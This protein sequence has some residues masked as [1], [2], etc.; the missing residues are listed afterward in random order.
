MTDEIQIN[1]PKRKRLRIF[2]LILLLIAILIVILVFIY[3]RQQQKITAVIPDTFLL[4]VSVTAPLQTWEEVESSS[5]WVNLRN[6][7][8][9][10]NFQKDLEAL[11][12]RLGPERNRKLLQIL[13][14]KQVA[15]IV[16]AI[17]TKTTAY[18]FAADLGLKIKLIQAATALKSTIFPES[19]D[20]AYD[21]RTFEGTEIH[22]IHLRAQ[23]QT[24]GYIFLR[25]IFLFSNDPQTLEKCIL[26]WQGK[27]TALS[28]NPDF[29]QVQ[30]NLNRGA[31]I[32]LYLNGAAAQ[33]WLRELLTP[34][35]QRNLKIL[36]DCIR[37]TG[38]GLKLEQNR[39]LVQGFSALDTTVAAPHLRHLLRQEAHKSALVEMIPNGTGF[40]S[41]LT[42][43][44][45][46]AI[47]QFS[48]FQLQQNPQ[49]WQDFQASERLVQKFIGINIDRDFLSWI[50]QD[51]GML[52]LPDAAFD[53]TPETVLFLKV[54]DQTQAR[55]SLE[56]IKQTVAERIPIN[57]KEKNYKG[58]LLGYLD[59]PFFLK[60]FFGGIFKKITKP[61]WCLIDDYVLFSDKLETLEY[62]IDA[63]SSKSTLQYHADYREIRNLLPST[64]N[65]HC[66]FD[67]DKLL[68]TLRPYLNRDAA[69]TLNQLRPYLE[70]LKGVGFSLSN[71][72]SGLETALGWVIQEPSTASVRLKWS[73]KT[74]SAIQAPVKAAPL[75]AEVDWEIVALV[76]DGTV[77]VLH[78]DGRPLNGWP[79]KL[80]ARL[81]VAPAI[82]DVDHDGKNE[83]V[84]VA[85]KEAYLWSATGQ[86]FNGWPV[87]FPNKVMAAPVLADLDQ[88]NDLEILFGAWDK[89]VHAY[90]HTGVPVTGWPQDTQA[91][92]SASPVVADIDHDNR[93]EIIVA[94]LDGRLYFWDQTGSLRE[95]WPLNLHTPVTAA[96]VLAD[97]N[98][99]GR[100]EIIV[101]AMNGQCYCWEATGDSVPGWP[102]RAD[103][104]ISGSP[105]IANVDGEAGPEVIVGAENHKV[106]IW[107]SDGS[108]LEGWPQS[109]HGK[110][111]SSPVVADIN[112]DNRMEIMVAAD[113]GK[114]YGWDHTGKMLP[115]WPLRGSGTPVLGDFDTDEDL[116]LVVGSWDRHIF[117]WDLMGHF[118]PQQIEWGQFQAQATNAGVYLP[119]AAE[120]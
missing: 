8:F 37:Y 71:K 53:K 120:E 19:D 26:A 12:A 101:G 6:T 58:I 17:G 91:L 10:S 41:Q 55:H 22:L 88:D 83:I 52:S 15:L 70:C 111:K 32:Q 23:K 4:T 36:T 44:N 104:I 49:E 106:F 64:A 13:F 63:H 66:Y 118:S 99:D 86:L 68:T 100:L 97:L 78:A 61:Y 79:K 30:A 7:P 96:P 21:Q 80:N 85:E 9:V 107:R 117:F 102:Q 76:E 33:P 109:T 75:D 27:L 87:I 81:Q 103:F 94:T 40:F 16:P 47:W 77:L 39:W 57:F 110:V 3:T 73:L 93:L 89:Q 82:G 108:L 2:L 51:I 72:Y 11:K 28:Q 115:G 67:T 56:T 31:K 112:A 105:A 34:E 25:N 116:D 1:R 29:L 59:L 113:D 98:G 92:I 45:F 54:K 69:K 74:E 62:V 65:I 84:V 46:N 114:L 38:L 48:R 18:I 90:H 14:D 95:N 43:D 5:G 24:L 50:G 42:F 60:V 35:T 20:L 119:P